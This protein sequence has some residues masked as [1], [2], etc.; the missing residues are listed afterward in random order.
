METAEKE[1]QNPSHMSDE[2]IV[3]MALQDQVWFGHIVERYQAKLGRYIGRLGIK[4][5]DDQAD[6][7]QEIFVKVYKN[8]NGFDT[9]LSFS[10]WVYR[11]AHNE[12]IS[13]YRKQKV[14]PE[15]HLVADGSDI[16]EL[17][18]DEDN[19]AASSFDASLDAAALEEALTGLDEK[20]RSVLILRYFEHLEYDE[21]SDILKIP[22]GTVGTLV[23]RGK[24]K[25]R[26]CLP[27]EVVEQYE[28]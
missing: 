14:R 27:T 7:L 16:V 25:L 24:H 4:N 3:T 12:A 5:P 11:I 8:L 26:E 10:S 22:V 6:I 2:E 28:K 18:K 13:W 1:S 23:H 21:I 9:S 19:D 20:Y 15:G 17:L